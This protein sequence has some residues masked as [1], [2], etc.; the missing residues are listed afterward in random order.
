MSLHLRRHIAR[1][2]ALGGS[3]IKQSERKHKKYA[4]E[5]DGNIFT[6]VMIATHKTKIR[7]K[8]MLIEL[9]IKQF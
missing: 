5:V 8:E 3:D 4:V 1:V 6:S 2:K 9:D 7:N